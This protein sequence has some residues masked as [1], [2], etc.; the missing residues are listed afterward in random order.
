MRMKRYTWCGCL[1]LLTMSATL[2]MSTKSS[3]A[4]PGGLCRNTASFRCPE[5]KALPKTLFQ[6][7]NKPHHK[8]TNAPL[9][10]MTLNVNYG[11]VNPAL[12]IK[13]ILDSKADVIA[14]QEITPYWERLLKRAFKKTHPHMLFATKTR[15]DLGFLSRY[16]ITFG[17]QLQ[18][19]KEGWFPSLLASIKT[20]LGKI[21]LLNLHLRPPLSRKRDVLS[22]ASAYLFKTPKI[23]H[24]ELTSYIQST[25]KL[26]PTKQRKRLMVLGDFNEDEGGMAYK[27]LKR[28][29]HMKSALAQY[30][31][32]TPTWHW[33]V[34]KGPFHF[35]LRARYDH[36]MFSKALTCHYAKVLPDAASDHFPIIAYFSNTSP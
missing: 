29:Q 31:R 13:R 3:L 7:M 25:Q 15:S 1:L 11:A 21:H 10:V 2:V 24:K 19:P 16:P 22:T 4:I 35:T 30:D 34:K 12:T 17:K 8:T 27:W 6:K 18:P 26:L 23:R 33:P 5:S 32:S 9:R 28:T 36:I 14:L 20:P